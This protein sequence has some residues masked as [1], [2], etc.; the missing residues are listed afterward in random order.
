MPAVKRRYLWVFWLLMLI[1]G[2]ASGQTVMI[3]IDTVKG[4]T[5]D[6]LAF[7]IRADQFNNIGAITLMIQ[8]NPAELQYDTA[9]SLHPQLPG[10]LVNKMTG[11]VQAIGFSWFSTSMN[12]VSIGTGILAT[13]KFV[14]L[15]DSSQLHFSP[16]CEI[17]NAVGTPLA[18][19]YQD[20]I[21][22]PRVPGLIAQPSDV[23]AKPGQSAVF[24]LTPV[25]PG[26]TMQWLISQD[27]TSWTDIQ[28]TG[29]FSG[30]TSASLT[31]NPV[32]WLHNGWGFKCLL[33]EGTCTGYS[34]TA[35]LWVDTIDT[36]GE[37]HPNSLIGI[38]YPNPCS[39]WICIPVNN[40]SLK[41]YSYSFSDVSGKIIKQ[42]NN[43]TFQTDANSCLKIQITDLPQGIYLFQA[44]LSDISGKI[45]P[46]QS[47]FEVK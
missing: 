24:S 45:L 37:I 38:L 10:M 19:T 44:T 1:S 47:K 11:S 33:T 5:G 25:Q 27:N 17:A 43:R 4:C 32:S 18:V 8:Y 42:E 13:M 9:I 16:Q 36:N 14:K 21:I 31:V 39:D 23:T 30:S 6:T 28:D 7:G 26:V 35:T 40:I 15:N 34:E 22:L 2:S 3:S 46:V 29:I 20:G 12:G 41:Y